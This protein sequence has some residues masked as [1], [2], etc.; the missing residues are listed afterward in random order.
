MAKGIDLGEKLKLEPLSIHDLTKETQYPRLHISDHD[1]SR[2]ADIPDE[3]EATIKYKVV[4][5][6]HREESRNGKKR[7]SCCL[8]LEVK[9]IDPPPAKGKKPKESDGGARKAMNDYFKDK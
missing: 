6:T 5:R 3:G 1:D 7:Y 4:D 9:S 2:L 8:V